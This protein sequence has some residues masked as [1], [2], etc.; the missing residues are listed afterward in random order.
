MNFKKLMKWSVKSCLLKKNLFYTFTL[1]FLKHLWFCSVHLFTAILLIVQYRIGLICG[2]LVDWLGFL[3]WVFKPLEKKT[4][5]KKKYRSR[6]RR[7]GTAQQ[8]SP[9]LQYQGHGT[10]ESKAPFFFQ[11]LHRDRYS[12]HRS[13]PPTIDRRRRPHRHSWPSD[14]LKYRRIAGNSL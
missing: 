14:S 6:R 3:L 11:K 5:I 10:P 13:L 1:N 12:R 2:R 9:I 8:V 7:W 4:W